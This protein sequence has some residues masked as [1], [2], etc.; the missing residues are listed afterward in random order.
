MAYEN[1]IKGLRKRDNLTQMELS[2]ILKISRNSI[3]AIENGSTRFPSNAV[4][5]LLSNYIGESEINIMTKI[6]FD[7][8]PIDNNNYDEYIAERYIAMMYLDGWNIDQCP[9]HYKV[10][11]RYVRCF[12]CRLVKKRNYKNAAIVALYKRFTFRVGEVKTKMDMIGYICDA[13][14][15]VM[16]IKEPFR[17]VRIIFNADVEEELRA[18]NFID[19]DEFRRTLCFEMVFVLFDNKNSNIIKEIVIGE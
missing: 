5:Q 1:F 10:F 16:G 9:Y 8:I 11:R 2:Q 12:E 3:Q 18:F 4:L 14:S 13:I 7:D 17:S 6:L 19:P 15:V